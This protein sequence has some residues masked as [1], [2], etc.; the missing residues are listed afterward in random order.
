[1]DRT[2]DGRSTNRTHI[3]TFA[4]LM[5]RISSV[6]LL[7]V[8]FVHIWV[9]HFTEIGVAVSYNEVASRLVTAFFIVVDT[10]LLAVTIYHGLNGVRNVAF[11]YLNNAAAKRGLTWGLGV[12]GVATFFFGLNALLPFITGQPLFFFWHP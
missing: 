6:L 8:M 1:M 3:G 2:I 12:I 11:D 4:W 7:V 10:S 5:Q 9:L